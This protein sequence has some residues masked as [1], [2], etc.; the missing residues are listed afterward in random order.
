MKAIIFATTTKNGNTSIQK[1]FTDEGHECEIINP[2]KIALYTAEGRKHDSLYIEDKHKLKLSDV[3]II[4][5][6]CGKGLR[7]VSELLEY[8]LE[9]YPKIYISQS[10]TGLMKAQ[11]KLQTGRILRLAKVPTPAMFYS[12]EFSD[13]KHIEDKIGYPAIVKTAIGGSQGTDVILIENQKELKL[14]LRGYLQRDK[15]KPVIVQKLVDLGDNPVSDIRVLVFNGKVIAAMER[16]AVNGSHVSNV[17]QGADTKEIEL[18]KREKQICVTASE[19]LGLKIAAVDLMR[20]QEKN[21]YIIE[22]NTN[23]GVKIQNVVEVDIHKALV[24]SIVKAK[25]ER[26]YNDFRTEYRTLN[27][28]APP[29]YKGVRLTSPMP[30]GIESPAPLS[31]RMGLS[32]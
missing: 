17:S 6:R 12:R 28:S 4:V 13:F 22:V 18:T 27:Q 16:T 20:D 15:P 24:K 9:K 21:P 26:N 1:A 19:V 10:P 3:D 25:E 31:E 14:A 5:T 11:S 23:Y 32:R 2:L 29:H 8:I 30:F 7:H